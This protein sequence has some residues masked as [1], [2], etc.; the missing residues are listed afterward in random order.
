MRQPAAVCCLLSA[1]ADVRASD[2]V[3]AYSKAKQL[4]TWNG[5]LVCGRLDPSGA[6]RFT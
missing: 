5:G 3:I 1:S 2:D 4:V 6:N